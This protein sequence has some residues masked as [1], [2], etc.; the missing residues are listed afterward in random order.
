MSKKIKELELNTLRNTFKGVRDMVLLEPLKLDSATE[1]EFR[2]KL[3]EKK[4]RVKLVKNTL[5]K[6]VF[7]ENGVAAETGSGPTLLAWG[8]D[9]VKE[10]ALAVSGLIKELKKD[11]KAPDK[12]KV[13]TAVSE[14]APV[15]M[16]L[17]EKI[18][19]RKE[20]IGGLVSAILGPGAAVAGAL[21]GPANN[22]AGI[23]K[24][25]EEKTAAPAAG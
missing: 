22:L 15:S 11:P 13:K 2:K 20:A 9:S 16:E 10:L 7:T 17:A 25:I 14:G 5:V 3:R 6:K 18:P 23:L 21:T 4:I 12:F 19:T 24:A 8:G 1:Y